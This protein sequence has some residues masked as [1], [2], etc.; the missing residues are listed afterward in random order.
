MY[1]LDDMPR[2]RHLQVPVQFLGTHRC[3]ERGEKEEAQ[4]WSCSRDRS[5]PWTDIQ[6]VGSIVALLRLVEGEPG[7]VS[8]LAGASLEAAH[9]SQETEGWEVQHR[10]YWGCCV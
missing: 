8:M 6:A 2:A 9:S 7:S 3:R 4:R 5:S 1:R 10:S